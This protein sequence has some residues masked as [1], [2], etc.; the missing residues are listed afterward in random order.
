[1]SKHSSEATQPSWPKVL[2]IWKGQLAAY[3]AH[4]RTKAN[5]AD[6]SIGLLDLW[7]IQE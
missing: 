2:Q 3:P 4:E 7:S 5:N 6:G 1:M